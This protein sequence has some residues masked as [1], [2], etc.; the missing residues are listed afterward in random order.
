L[1]SPEHSPALLRPG[2]FSLGCNYWASHAGTSMWRDWRPAQVR[3]DLARL[4]EHGVRLLRVFP[5]WP[6]FQPL[7]RIYGAGATPGEMRFGDQPL[8]LGAEGRDGVSREMLARFRTLCDFASEFDQRLVVGLVTGW[9][10]GRLFMPPGLEGRDPITDPLCLRWQ[11]RFVRRFVTDLRDHPAI[12]CWDLGNECNCMGSAPDADAAYLWTASIA[13]SI[14]SADPA[15]PIVSG[16]HSLSSEIGRT[17]PDVR[18]RSNP[19]FIEDQAE[20]T[21]VLTTHPYPY[22]CRHTG[23]DAITDL[24][25]TLHATAE[26]RFYGDLGGRPAFAEEIGTMGPMISSDRIAADFARVN[27]CS[28]WANDC[29]G[30]LWWCAHD[31][32]ALT[33]PPYERN[34]V[35]LELG[36]LR[37]D[38]TPKPV[39]EEIARFDAFLRGLP[40]THLPSRLIDAVCILTHEQDTWPVAYGAQVLAKQAGLEIEFRHAAQ[41]LP[42]APVYLLPSLQGICGVP[43]SLWRELLRRCEAGA[44]LYVS[45]GDGV[46][47]GFNEAAGVELITRSRAR[48]PLFAELAGEKTRLPLLRAE[49]L[50]FEVRDAEVLAS[51]ADCASPVFWRRR[52]GRGWLYVYTAPLEKSL[53]LEAG[54][55]APEAP[56]YWRVYAEFARRHRHERWL[57]VDSPRVAATEHPLGDERVVVLVHHDPAPLTLDLAPRRGAR[58]LRALRG[59][60]ATTADGLV[61]VRLAAHDAC[62]LLLGPASRES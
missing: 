28:L 59:D 37:V 14:R 6:D 58:L 10:S 20:L 49:D 8:D 54:A 52:V 29:R 40:F 9:M 45:L 2:A 12:D 51:R 22:W 39:L 50:R 33:H 24:R 7:R 11:M 41:P 17:P 62:V 30:F 53:T 26:T 44:A 55:F 27:L 56:P 36:L 60:V 48:T 1:F 38:G 61:R 42:E 4:A 34:N 25:V 15:R 35:E 31:Q 16:M 3:A 18:G 19:W 13:Q 43:H 32:T 47:P 46:L 57:P 5:L 21:D 23:D